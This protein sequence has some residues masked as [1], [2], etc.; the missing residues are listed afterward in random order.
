MAYGFQ[1]LLN[2][3]EDGIL[4]GILP[5]NSK[6]LH[7][8]EALVNSLH[9]RLVHPLNDGVIADLD[10]TRFVFFII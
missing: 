2:Y 5:G 9:L 6:M 3:P 1:R 4:A 7:G 10:A 8:D